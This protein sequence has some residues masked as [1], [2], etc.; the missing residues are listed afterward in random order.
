MNVHPR[1]ARPSAFTH[2]VSSPDRLHNVLSLLGIY[3]A[4]PIILRRVLRLSKPKTHIVRILVRNH[5]FIVMPIP[6]PKRASLFVPMMAMP[7]PT[8]K[9]MPALTTMPMPI[10]RRRSLPHL[11]PHSP[12]PTLIQTP[13]PRRPELLLLGPPIAEVVLCVVQNLPRLGSVLVR[14]ARVAGDHGRVVK[15]GEQAA[16]VL[17]EDELLLGALDGREELCVVR[18]LELLTGLVSSESL[19]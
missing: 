16:A 11:V 14:G 10:C 9:T 18:L 6:I 13:P 8:P 17:G 2:P 3:L 4:G 15:E 5:L 19:P 12:L 1:L 7:M